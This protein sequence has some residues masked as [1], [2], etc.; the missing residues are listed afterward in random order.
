MSSSDYTKLVKLRQIQGDISNNCNDSSTCG[1]RITNEIIVQ[2]RLLQTQQII[3]A[4]N[5]GGSCSMN[6]NT[7]SA[8]VN[9]IGR[10]GANGNSAGFIY[11][12]D[13]SG[14]V[15]PDPN[16]SLLTT[17]NLGP[18]TNLTFTYTASLDYTHNLLGSFSTPYGLS[19]TIITS[20][21]W[22][23]NLF[24]SSNQDKRQIN[25]YAK[26]YYVDIVGT[27][28]LMVDNSNNV[29]N[30]INF[31]YP[32]VIIQVTHSA[33]VQTTLLPNTNYKI[34]IEIWVWS[35]TANNTDTISLYFRSTGGN[36]LS[37]VHTTLYNYYNL[38]DLTSDQYI[39]G[40]KTFKSPVYIGNNFIESN[41][42]DTG[43]LV[44]SGGVGI[45]GNTY[46]GGNLNVANP[47]ILQSNVFIGST[48]NSTSIGTGALTVLG[49]VGITGNTFVGGN[50]YVNN[51]TPSI[52]I[53]TG[54]LIVKGGIGILGNLYVG[55]N[56]RLGPSILQNVTFGYNPMNSITSGTNNSAFGYQ[57][58]YS[59]TSGINNNAFGYNSLY[60]N[61]TGS[62]NNAFGY[63]ALYNNVASNNTAIGH[64]A[65]TA[66]TAGFNNV[67]VG[68]QAM[69]SST[70]SNYATIIGASA[71]YNGTTGD[72]NTVIGNAA[73][74]NA[75]IGINNVAV[76]DS[77][78]GNIISGS[79]NTFVG[80]GAGSTINVFYS[81]AIGYNA[82]ATQNNQIVLG[83]T[84]ESVSIP[85]NVYIGNTLPSTSYNSGAIVVN[86]GVGVSGNIYIGGLINTNQNVEN[87]N[88]LAWSPSL[89]VSF[90]NTM[91]YYLY[92][93]P[94]APIT[95]LI[96][97]SVPLSVSS[98]ICHTFTFIIPTNNMS[99]FITATSILVNGLSVTLRGTSSISGNLNASNPALILQQVTLFIINGTIQNAI[100]MATAY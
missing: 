27:L 12:L 53:N 2:R 56:I 95:T 52:S 80:K 88:Y 87:M 94:F 61:Q 10:T 64:Q 30:G 20:G 22:D 35:P 40:T 73:L 69:Y 5:G 76:G 85:G 47:S 11:I 23:F 71:W 44:V 59:N 9:T 99:W 72:G 37:H 78:G 33:Y 45:Q 98:Y 51:T 97:N 4:N 18:T 89:T 1:S 75:T 21:M 91:I 57:P 48:Q 92:G 50:I 84:S 14:N 8:P 79:Y 39:T 26:I 3:N 28:T 63:Y 58:L 100:T 93:F 65:A 32:N 36:T 68:Y 62:A 19:S 66:N 24:T 6:N 7:S 67:A 16:G 49:G 31:V 60:L 86:G 25:V 55:G 41:S 15:V 81:T 77:V 13:S 90:K 34:L 43:S 82:A 74:Y 83:T 96:I 38:V 54:A 17:P 46:I 70:I 29:T 42:V